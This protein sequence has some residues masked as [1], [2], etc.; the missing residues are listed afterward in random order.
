M[1]SGKSVKHRADRR[2]G[3]S[4]RIDPDPALNVVCAYVESFDN[5]LRIMGRKMMAC[6]KRHKGIGLAA[7]QVGI[8]QRLVVVRTREAE[9]FLVNPQ[10]VSV[11]PEFDTE[12]ERS[13]SLPDQSYD[14]PRHR[15]IEVRARDGM[16][17][18]LY[19]VAYDLLARVI[20]H[21]VDHLD[22]ILIR[23]KGIEAP[24]ATA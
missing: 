16:G 4:V 22:G 3:F 1:T 23:A 15:R 14:V 5:Q 11:T 7:P 6:M 18:D 21:E 20:Q 2:K 13:L 17:R 9:M 12:R 8:T 24:E 19:F 10:I